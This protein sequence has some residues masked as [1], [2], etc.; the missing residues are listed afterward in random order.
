MRRN[1]TSAARC[2]KECSKIDRCDRAGTLP[3]MRFQIGIV[4]AWMIHA[5]LP[6]TA[7]VQQQ[8]T[9]PSSAADDS[10]RRFLQN[11]L[12][13]PSLD[14]ENSTRYFAAFVDLN[15]DGT[16]E[17]I[18]SI[19]GPRWCGSGGCSTLILA[20]EGSSYRVVTKITITQPPIRVLTKASN[21]WRNIGVW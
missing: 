19:T 17:A 16:D 14:H 12:R 11:Y 9:V 2:S 1:V 3:L 13:R 21:G 5:A 8:P 18:V 15:D 6:A 20:Q 10:L 7:Q 4:I